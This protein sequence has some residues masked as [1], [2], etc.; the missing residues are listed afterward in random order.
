MLRVNECIWALPF[1]FF[2]KWDSHSF[3]R[4]VCLFSW[5]S[6]PKNWRNPLV[7]FCMGFV[8]IPTSV[9]IARPKWSALIS[10]VM[11][12][13][14]NRENP[15]GL[16]VYHTRLARGLL[17]C[18]PLWFASCHLFVRDYFHGFSWDFSRDFSWSYLV[19]RLEKQDM[20]CAGERKGLPLVA[21]LNPANQLK[22][23][24]VC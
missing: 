24:W 2:R 12:D 19:S 6:N 11:V 15:S 14:I 13:T 22:S 5:S 21:T 16:L 3:A 7:Q 8:Y 20:E 4:A 17:H 10:A 23:H 18:S 1:K 9:Y